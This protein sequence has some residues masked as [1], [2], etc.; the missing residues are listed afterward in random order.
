MSASAPVHTILRLSGEGG[1]YRIE[2][3]PLPTGWQFRVHSHSIW[4]EPDQG[5]P[6]DLPWLPSLDAAISRINRGWPMLYPS[7]VHPDF[8]SAIRQR[9]LAFHDHTPL[10]ASEL[11]RWH[12]L[13]VTAS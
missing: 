2:G 6:V 8:I 12:A 9:V 1:G 4:D 11:D 5:D 7:E 10:K 3:Q 13:G